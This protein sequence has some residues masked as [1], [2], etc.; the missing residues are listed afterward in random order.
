MSRALAVARLGIVVARIIFCAP[1]WAIFYLVQSNRQ[2]PSWSIGQ[3]LFVRAFYEL[4]AFGLRRGHLAALVPA[5]PQGLSEVLHHKNVGQPTARKDGLVAVPP[6]PLERIGSELVDI[7]SRNGVAVNK[8]A[9]GY[10]FGE[11]SDDGKA[12]YK[13]TAN[14]RVILHIHGGGFLVSLN[15]NSSCVLSS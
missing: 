6:A 11:R 4:G 9:L 15:S 1:L 10:W 3:S 5:P 2:R 8:P 7:A 13:A 12:G 14:E